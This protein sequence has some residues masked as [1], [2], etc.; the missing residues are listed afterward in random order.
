MTVEYICE[1]GYGSEARII[2]ELRTE[3]P[4]IGGIIKT[5]QAVAV[6]RRIEFNKTKKCGHKRFLTHSLL[7][8]IE[9]YFFAKGVYKFAHICRPLGSTNDSYIYEWAFGRDG[10]PWYVYDEK[11]NQVLVKLDDWNEFISA[12]N[13]VGINL[14]IDCTDSLDGKLS[15]NIVHQLY[16]DN[17]FKI[18]K[19]NRLWKRIDFG[20]KSI[21]ID[22]DAVKKFLIENEEDL[23]KTLKS[24]RYD[25]LFLILE[26]LENDGKISERKKG[27]LEVLVFDYRMSTLEHL[28]KKGL[29]DNEP[30]TVTTKPGKKDTI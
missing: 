30:L 24:K 29:G 18:K 11:G 4:G 26:Y 12:F 20:Y 28:N 23:R 13:K 22:Y 6:A 19:L 27:K 14:S 9:D 3:F 8:K 7:K 16:L 10:F 21:K 15:K 2:V 25:L 5:Q 1:G 17:V